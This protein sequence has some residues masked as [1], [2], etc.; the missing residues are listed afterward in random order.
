MEQCGC[1]NQGAVLFN[2]Q[3]N[4]RSHCAIH[5]RSPSTVFY[6]RSGSAH[7]IL[8]L[9]KSVA[10]ITAELAPVPAL[11]PLV[12]VLCGIIE[13]CE[14]VAHNRFGKASSAC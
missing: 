8:S 4:R 6:M 1:V 13:L 3:L 14:K 2:L 12:E 5:V 9:G 10:Q 7:L 11:Y